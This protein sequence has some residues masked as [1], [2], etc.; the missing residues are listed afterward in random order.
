MRQHLIEVAEHVLH[1]LALRPRLDG[2]EQKIVKGPPVFKEEDG[3]KRDDDEEPGLFGEIGDAQP[4]TLGDLG[5]VIAMAGEKSLYKFRAP[6]VPP[7]LSA[8]LARN[9]AGT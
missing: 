6:L 8:N 9:L 1:E 7:V 2:G 4:D 5:N 3:Q